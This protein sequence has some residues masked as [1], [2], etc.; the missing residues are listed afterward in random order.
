MFIIEYTFYYTSHSCSVNN[1]FLII[2]FLSHKLADKVLYLKNGASLRLRIN[3]VLIWSGELNDQKRGYEFPDPLDDRYFE[4]IPDKIAKYQDRFRV[5]QIGFSLFER[6]WTLRGMVNLMM[7]FIEH[8]AFVRDLLH[9]I[10]DYNI[11]QIEKALEYEI[12]ALYFGDDWGQQRGLL[13][14]PKYW[15]EFIYP[16][17]R[18]MYRVVRDAGKYVFIHSC[19]DLDELF[20]DLIAIGLNCF[21]PFQPEVMDIESL[22]KRY[23]G[24]LAFFGG[25]PPRGPF[26]LAPLRM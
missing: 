20:D 2:I 9:T 3:I 19:G 4:D 24:R 23:R 6:A 16:E 15:Y 11:A 7:D 5:F 18:R 26:L 13:M 14:G 21:N 17:L 1:F 10:A 8:P 22:L 25:Y 12:D